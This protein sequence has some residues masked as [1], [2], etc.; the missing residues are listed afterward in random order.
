MII[1]KR[2]LLEPSFELAK[3]PTSIWRISNPILSNKSSSSSEVKPS[4]SKFTKA[5]FK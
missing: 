3:V 4:S 2:A 1:A 5:I